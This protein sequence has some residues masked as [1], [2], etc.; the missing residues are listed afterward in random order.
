[1]RLRAQKYAVT[2]IKL[3]KRLEGW[4]KDLWFLESSEKNHKN[5]YKICV[6]VGYKSTLVI[7]KDR[8]EDQDL[9]IWTPI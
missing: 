7:C 4:P 2:S 8:M 3:D 9:S 1:M 5:I 6:S